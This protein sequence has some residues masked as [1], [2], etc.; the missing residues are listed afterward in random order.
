MRSR[1]TTGATRS[2]RRCTR[3]RGPSRSSRSRPRTGSSGRPTGSASSRPTRARR[4]SSAVPTRR[5]VSPA[6]RPRLVP[7]SKRVHPDREL[8]DAPRGGG[9]GRDDGAAVPRLRRRRAL[10]LRRRP[11][12]RRRRGRPERLVG[13]ARWVQVGRKTVEWR[14]RDGR[15]FPAIVRYEVE[16]TGGTAA[17]RRS[18]LLYTS[19]S[20]RDRQKSRMPSSA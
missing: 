8:R 1:R 18:C 16:G 17:E 11:P 6:G 2:R 20:P 10:R 3:R 13:H 7:T 5:R 12:H 14:L 15:P 9:R 4:R 19:P